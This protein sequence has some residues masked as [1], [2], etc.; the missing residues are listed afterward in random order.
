ME[1]ENAVKLKVSPL[2]LIGTELKKKA[3]RLP[4]SDVW[5]PWEVN[6]RHK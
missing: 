6:N 3:I 4:I 5:K 1:K 2:T